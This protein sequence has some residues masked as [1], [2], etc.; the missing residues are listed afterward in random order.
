M[1]RRNPFR[2]PELADELRRAREADEARLRAEEDAARRKQF[3]DWSAKRT[4]AGG[5]ILFGVLF[6][7]MR[8]FG[9]FQEREA[10]EARARPLIEAAAAGKPKL[11][12]VDAGAVRPS[13][14]A[15]LKPENV[16]T[17]VD[18]HADELAT[19]FDE[20]LAK[21]ALVLGSGASHAF[22][23][24]WTIAA[25]GTTTRARLETGGAAREPTDVEKC[26]LA[27]VSNW[28]FGDVGGEVEVIAWRFERCPSS[29]EECARPRH[30]TS[31]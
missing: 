17:V 14:K 19:C 21:G 31:N 15:F 4:L 7:V 8:M 2:D 1:A 9:V 12:V 3:L 13:A 22:A 24:S 10:N 26:I 25:D 11:V 18:R 6:F 29:R 30:P 27:G 23:F 28:N 5:G 16:R 20:G